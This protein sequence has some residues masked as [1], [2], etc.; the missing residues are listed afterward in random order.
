MLRRRPRGSPRA[1]PGALPPPP[2]SAPQSA[3]SRPCAPPHPRAL[4]FIPHRAFLITYRPPPAPSQRPSE[5]GVAALCP[6]SP[7]HRAFSTA[8]HPSP[9]RLG[10]DRGLWVRGSSHRKHH[11]GVLSVF[12]IF[13]ASRRSERD[14]SRSEGH[15][16]SEQSHLGLCSACL[17]ARLVF[18]PS[19]VRLAIKESTAVSLLHDPENPAVHHYPSVG[20]EQRWEGGKQQKEPK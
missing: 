12:P 20:P 11:F 5:R 2:H 19:F 4:C 8:D 7:P 17:P 10:A 15:G 13:Y 16:H 14:E 9:R 18:L 1:L 6:P 3:A